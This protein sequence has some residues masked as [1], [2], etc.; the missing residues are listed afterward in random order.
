[1]QTEIAL[2]MQG[3]L[4]VG[5]LLDEGKAAPEMISLVK[6]NNCGKALD[7]AR[8]ARDMHGGNG[9]Q[10]EYHVMR[11]AQNLET[12]NTYEGTHD[13]HALILGRAQTGIQAF[14]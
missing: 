3:S 7:I 6:R 12:V 5:R 11:H 1:M 13:V 8:V 9:I 14:F 10:Q 4:R 2:G